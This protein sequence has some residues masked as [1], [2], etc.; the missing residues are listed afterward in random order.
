M[1]LRAPLVHSKRSRCSFSSFPSFTK[2][3]Q[4]QPIAGGSRRQDDPDYDPLDD[5]EDLAIAETAWSGQAGLDVE[6]AG[7]NNWS[8]LTS[9]PLL[10]L[11][12][13]G[14]LLLFATIGR[15]IHSGG[16]HFDLQALGTAAPFLGAW[17]L[18]APLLGA[19][20]PGATRSTGDALGAL[21]KAWAVAVPLGLAGRGLIKGEVPPTPFIGVAMLMTLVFL[22]TWRSVYV[23]LTGAEIKGGQGNKKSGVFDVF[24]MVTTLINR[25]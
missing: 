23:Q 15:S 25:W 12:D 8:D 18:V 17:L 1:I 10:A 3:K 11:G 6:K 13:V 7:N 24:R 2:P 4:Q 5:A 14:F 19:Y 22:A 9:R 20:T 21:V 16:F